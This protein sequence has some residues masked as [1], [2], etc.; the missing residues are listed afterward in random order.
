MAAFFPTISSLLFNDVYHFGVEILNAM[1]LRDLWLNFKLG[2][3]LMLFIF[4]KCATQVDCTHA[5][6]IC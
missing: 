2:G 6:T 3:G 5:V 4:K 1:I